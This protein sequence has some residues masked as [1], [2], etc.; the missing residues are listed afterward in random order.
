LHSLCFAQSCLVLNQTPQ[1]QQVLLPR[2]KS[3]YLLNLA[4]LDID[5]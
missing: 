4:N 2:I 1:H 5:V 3:K